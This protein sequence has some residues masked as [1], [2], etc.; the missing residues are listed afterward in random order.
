MK[1]KTVLKETIYIAVVV[2]LLSVIMELVFFFIG[3]WAFPVLWG[4][5]LGGGVAV[6]NFF[7]MALTVQKNIGKESSQVKSSVTLSMLGR[8]AMMAAAAVL[9]G[10]LSCFNIYAV[11]IPFVFPR[12]AIALRP[13]VAKLGIMEM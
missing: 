13:V 2:I 5:V 9:G 10:V 8:Y 12:I 7:L 1:N 3:K 4:N 11:V 6:L